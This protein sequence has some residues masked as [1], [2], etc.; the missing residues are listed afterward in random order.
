MDGLPDIAR[1]E[2]GEQRG[3]DVGDMV[4]GDA[5]IGSLTNVLGA[6]QVV[7]A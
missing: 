3:V 2:A 4:E 5:A 7:L 6:E 1:D